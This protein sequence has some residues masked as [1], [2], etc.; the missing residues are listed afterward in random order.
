M[1]PANAGFNTIQLGDFTVTTILDG[2]RPMEKPNE[3]FGTDQSAEAVSELLA[4]ENLPADRFVNMF[5]P[6]LVKTGSDLVLFDTGLGDAGRANG[7][8]LLTERMKA[9]GY[10]PEDVTVVVITHMH[11]DHIGGLTEGETPAFANARYVAG[12]VEYDFWTAP[13]RMSGRPKATRRRW[14]RRSSRWPRRPRSSA[15]KR[16]SCRASPRWRRSATRRGT[17]STCW[18]RAASSS[19]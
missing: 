13:D 12:Q 9:A 15:A 2:M 1:A 18:N 4:T 19:C 11:G 3:T 8:G 16:K 7:M 10:S 6:T 5:T 17:W 14:P